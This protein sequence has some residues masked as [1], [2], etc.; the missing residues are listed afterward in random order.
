MT[1][2]Y[3]EETEEN[4]EELQISCC[5]MLDAAAKIRANTS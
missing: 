4:Y 2:F 3:F 1:V 5:R